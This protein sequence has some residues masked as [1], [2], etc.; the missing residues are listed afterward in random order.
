MKFVDVFQFLYYL[1]EEMSRCNCF[2]LQLL[3]GGDSRWTLD[4][5]AGVWRESRHRTTKMDGTNESRAAV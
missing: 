3:G 1:L 5:E 2:S 4:R